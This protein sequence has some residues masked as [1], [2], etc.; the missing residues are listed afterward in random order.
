[1]PSL[2]RQAI[3]TRVCLLGFFA[4][5]VPTNYFGCKQTSCVLID[6]AASDCLVREKVLTPDIIREDVK[7]IYTAS[8]NKKKKRE[9]CV[10]SSCYDRRIHGKGQC[11]G[12]TQELIYLNGTLDFYTQSRLEAAIG[13]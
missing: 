8:E 11:N 10:F 9:N 4:R 7:C 1:M 6:S 5:R 3:A 13:L 2:S 12:L